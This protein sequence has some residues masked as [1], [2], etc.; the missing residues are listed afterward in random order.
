MKHIGRVIEFHKTAGHPVTDIDSI[1]TVK[2]RT[3]RLNLIL[4]ELIELSHAYGLSETFRNKLLAQT[5]ID[6][7]DTFEFNQVESLDAL[8][9]LEV[10][11]LGGYCMSGFTE[12]ADS[13]F[14]EVMDSNMSKFCS[15]L[16]EVHAST[17]KHNDWYHKLVNGVYVLYR[18]ADNKIM[19]GINYF[20]PNLEK[21]L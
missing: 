17:S 13:A 18:T 11:V 1:P 21:F 20:K 2:Q 14:T 19:K 4:E 16:D 8:C 12:V 5:T 9:D 7:K 10:V 6:C 15:S 3:L